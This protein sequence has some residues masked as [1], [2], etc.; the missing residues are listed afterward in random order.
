MTGRARSAAALA[1]TAALLL[2]AALVVLAARATPPPAGAGAML[3]PEHAAYVGNADARGQRAAHALLVLGVALLVLSGAAIG[4]RL[5]RDGSTAA[6]LARMEGP[7]LWLSAAIVAGLSVLQ[8]AAGGSWIPLLAGGVLLY[9][10]ARGSRLPAPWRAQGV[11]R[12]AALGM[13]VVASGLGLLVPL[14]LSTAPPEGL[15]HIEYHHA[16]VLE[17]AH[18]L[19]LGERIYRDFDVYYGTLPTALL[20]LGERL[21]SGL[22]WAGDVRAL[23][24]LDAAFVAGIAWLA[25]RVG[26]RRW[27]RVV[28]ALLLCLPAYHALSKGVVLPNHSAWRTLPLVGGLCAVEWL[29]RRPGAWRAAMAGA[30][31]TLLVLWNAES[32]LAAVAGMLAY[33]FLRGGLLGP[34]AGSRLAQM[35]RPAV[36]AVTGAAAALGALLAGWRLAFGHWPELLHPRGLLFGLRE[37]STVGL[38]GL[39]LG[40]DPLAVLLFGQAAWVLLATGLSPLRRTGDGTL[41]HA[42][43]RRA[44]IATV[45]LV[46]GGYYAYRPDPQKLLA[47]L[48]LSSLLWV[49]VASCV[50]RAPAARR[51]GHAPA[52]T[53]MVLAAL[54]ILPVLAGAWSETLGRQLAVG[55]QL[56]VGPDRAG[57]GTVSGVRVAGP[58]AEHLAA[59]A[60]RLRHSAGGGRALFL[61]AHPFTMARLSGVV[62]DHRSHHLFSHARTR[63]AHSALLEELRA[64]GPARLLVDDPVG[65]HAGSPEERRWMARV[66]SELHPVYRFSRALDGWRVLERQ[67]R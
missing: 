55:R 16:F 66:E 41:P 22:S 67:P 32:G 9:A 25:F 2:L 51:P 47:A 24:L 56:L 34:H 8:Q 17:P 28:L 11:S 23:Q 10:W 4:R 18:R 15:A 7:L 58:S 54:V 37:L 13:L 5:D 3:N 46:W 65:G 40:L 19:A 60:G 48:A 50:R 39:H 30:V 29:G 35:A 31:A 36:L 57:A 20:A 64:R 27:S 49:E 43:A 1:L 45:I 59:K 12:V 61:T 38:P 63:A 14:D 42:G 44:A 52:A 26:R 33:A 21:R 6:R 53:A 62:L